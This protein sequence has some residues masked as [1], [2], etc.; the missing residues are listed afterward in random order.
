MLCVE[1]AWC[2]VKSRQGLEF[3][4]VLRRHTGQRTGV[5]NEK[6]VWEAE[7]KG[8]RKNFMGRV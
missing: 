3:G 6:S 4:V 2:G 1:W 7:G 8:T 5:R